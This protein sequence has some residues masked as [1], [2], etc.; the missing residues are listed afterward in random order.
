[1]AGGE[2]R[3]GRAWYV[4]R[5]LMKLGSQVRHGGS[6]QTSTH[7]SA[8]TSVSTRPGA[9]RLSPELAQEKRSRGQFLE[10]LGEVGWNE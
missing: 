8:G 4:T 5:A 3:G 6:K 9:R 1:G 7:G 10:R 2:V